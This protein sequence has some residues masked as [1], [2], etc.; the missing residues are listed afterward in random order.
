MPDQS[1]KH[2]TMAR[3]SL[4]AFVFTCMTIFGAADLL[5]LGMAIAGIVIARGPSRRLFHGMRDGTERLVA[6]GFAWVFI[7]K[8]LSAGWA[9]DRSQ[10]V[11]N[12][13]NHLHFLL[14]PA[15]IPLL[16]LA[17]FRP[18][19][20]EPFLALTMA[21]LAFWW[22]GV[23]QFGWIGDRASGRFEAGVR[24]FGMLATVLA[25]FVLWLVAAVTRPGRI[26]RQQGMLL[27]GLICGL[28]AL[29]GT[30]ARTELLG[31][32]VGIAG[33]AMYRLIEKRSWRSACLAA[34]LLTGF[35]VGSIYGL[36]ERFQDVEREVSAYFGQAADRQ[37]AVL[38]SVGGRLEMYRTGIEGVQEK[39]WLGWGAGVRPRHLS[40]HATD[41]GNP[42]HYSNFHSLFLQ[43]LLEIGMIGSALSVLVAI[44]LFRETIWRVWRS[45]QR[46]LGLLC[47]LLWFSYLW[48]SLANATF[49]YGLPNAV[50]VLFTA[51]F[52]VESTRERAKGEV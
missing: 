15:L 28:V 5:L 40:H 46:E 2:V 45:G 33:I 50:F 32:I 35:S 1:G 7:V 34:L 23:V 6:V 13:F 49:G 37:A 48:K 18:S 9:V 31:V 36:K 22:W 20:V 43:S 41:P 21:V 26:P 39:P 17:N 14:W 44:F 25:F 29:Y 24:S 3:F 16:R 8:L 30:K 27:I 42:L 47:A 19:R 12:A 38:T 52:W 51:W 10:A 11:D 4:G